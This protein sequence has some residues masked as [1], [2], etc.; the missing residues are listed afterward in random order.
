MKRLLLCSIGLLLLTAGGAASLLEAAPDTA[1]YEPVSCPIDGQKAQSY[2][3][4]S[5]QKWSRGVVV[6]YSAV[7]P[8][9][10]QA[11]ARQMFGHQLVE[12]NGMNWQVS[13]SDS[14]RTRSTTAKSE[15]LIDYRI[16]RASKPG[17]RY[18]VLYGQILSKKVA[19]VEATFD[20]GQI[21]REQ[22]SNGVFAL[23]APGA[24]GVCE[25][26]LFGND[27]QIFRQDNL[28]S[29]NSRTQ[30]YRCLPEAQRI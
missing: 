7:C 13:G 15:R 20:N 21:L 26:R 8:G 27:N 1:L 22:A 19:V 30:Q 28:A 29:K 16:S 4:L 24:T 3:V 25:L 5:K 11:P 6:L 2:Q 10:S 12:R 9:S 18:T 17:D 23:V 14:F